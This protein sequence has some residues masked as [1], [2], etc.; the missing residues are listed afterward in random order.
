MKK[1]IERI[2]R[3]QDNWMR[4]EFH[5]PAAE[6]DIS[7]FEHDNNISI[8]PSYKD[9]LL[10]SD[11]GELFGAVG[12]VWLYGVKATRFKIGDDFSEGMVPK[13]FLILGFWD[14]RHICF[15]PERNKFLFYEYE[16]PDEIDCECLWFDS[17]YDVMEYLIDVHTG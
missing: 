2:K 11:G 9:F 1:I 16:T 4:S 15:M 12:N 5:E 8:P 7:A 6:S 3:I 14:S 13:D 10:L 17:F